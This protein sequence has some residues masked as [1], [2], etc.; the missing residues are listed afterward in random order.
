M[1][2]NVISESEFTVQG[3]GVH[4]AFVD[5]VEALKNYT[6]CDVAI[7][8][9]RPAD[10][11][12]IHSPGPYSLKKLLFDKGAKVVSAHVT[13]AS[14]V[15]S[16]LLAQ[17]WE[18]LAGLYLRWFYNRAD[19]VLAV[20]SEVIDELREL[21]V[22]KPIYLVPNTISTADFHST[23]EKREQDRRRLGIEDGQF[24]VMAC[25]Q[26]Q[27][28]KRVDTFVA[29]AK[30]LPSMR[31]VWV[32]GIPF[33]GL[34]ADQTAMKKV[35]SNHL[36]NITFTGLIGRKEVERWYR[37]A[38][39]FFLPS[40]QETFGLVIV[41]AAAAGL[42]LLLRDLDQYRMTFSD[43][44]ESGTD[45]DFTTKI[46]RFSSDRTYYQHWQQAAKLIADRYDSK[47]GASRLIEVYEKAV[48][49]RNRQR[50]PEPGLR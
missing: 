9:S 47:A 20:S 49:S 6:D 2:V 11:T 35:M 44:Y 24:V 12:H 33:K 36:D 38:D 32:G 40:S 23:P 31:F 14:F 43:G 21:G 28:R 46:Q 27:P 48:E 3:H 15:G 18:P 4:S 50:K 16:L 25:G 45:E 26:V 30:A 29:A 39:L 8:T 42:P 17:Y 10:I 37:A 13:P 22:R 19:A 7:N 5:T 41:E 1:R 34:A